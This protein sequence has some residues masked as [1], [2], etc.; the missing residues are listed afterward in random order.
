MTGIGSPQIA[1]KESKP[2]VFKAT[3][4]PPVLLPLMSK[5]SCGF[6]KTISLATTSF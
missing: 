6:F 3:V 1:I 2:A 4:L 5:I